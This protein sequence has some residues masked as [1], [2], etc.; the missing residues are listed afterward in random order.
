MSYVEDLTPQ[1]A[2]QKLAD[3][4]LLVDV[5]SV[6][7]WKHIGVPDTSA[8]GRKP[9][10][11]QWNLNGGVPNNAFLDQLKDALGEEDRGRD[12]VFLCRSGARSA[13]AAQAAA[14]AGYTAYNVLEGFE[15]DADEYGVRNVAGWKVRGLAW[16]K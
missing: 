15:G 7:E 11:V 16:T 13:A 8:L 6:S 4:A 1:Q 2:W 14:A 10:F 3:G 12:L 9:L 5:R